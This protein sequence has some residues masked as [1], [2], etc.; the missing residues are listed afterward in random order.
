MSY[1]IIDEGNSHPHLSDYNYTKIEV[2]YALVYIAT[3]HLLAGAY[4]RV[5]TT[6]LV[7]C[8]I[9]DSLK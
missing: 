7:G 4:L 6:L 2:Y 1:I 3:K 5:P 8:W 9:F